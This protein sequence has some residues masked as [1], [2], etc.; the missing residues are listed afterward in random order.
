MAA[1][2]GALR[3][4]LSASIAKFQE[5]MGKAAQ[6][7]KKF[8]DGAKK[9]GESLSRVGTKMSIALTAPIVAFSIKAVEAGKESAQALGQVEAA[10]ESTGGQ[11][12]KTAVEL[13]KSAKALE[14]LSTFDDDDILK[15]VTANLLT[16]GNVQGDVFDRAQKSVVNMAARLGEDLQPAALLVGRALNDPIAAITRL[17]RA[18]I[19]LD[20]SQKKLIKSF[21]QT[22]QGVKAQ[23]IIL[24]AFE[25]KF[26]GAA[27]AARKNDPFA[28]L[29]QSIRNLLEAAGPLITG[30][31]VP[32]TDALKAI[33]DAFVALPE[34]VQGV[35][36]GLALFAATLGPMIAL[37]GNVIKLIGFLTPAVVALSAAVAGLS[38][39]I[40]ITIGALTAAVAAVVIFWKSIK[41]I[42]HGDF[43]KAWEDAKTT[44]KGMW[45]DLTSMFAKKPIIAPIKVEPIGGVKGK[46]GPLNFSLGP[47]AQKA[48]D[49]FGKAL[50]GMNDKIAAAFDTLSEPKSIQKANELNAQIDEYVRTAKEAGVNTATFAGKIAELRKQIDDLTQAGLD[51]EAQK[52][53][54]PSIRTR[55]P[56]AGSRTGRSIR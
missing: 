55:S 35:V 39:P 31:L 51:K 17:E 56:S 32:V 48:A 10:L 11:S 1:V 49:A 29:N 40:W 8:A 21:V 22:G 47:E 20:D 3:A 52:F 42:L 2:I 24:D 18:G 27:E 19:H 33:A 7:V 15:K 30:F 36:V 25:K 16:F 14:Q 53:G 41:D 4:E 5:D 43:S 45:D 50:R 54:V 23:G 34:P 26:G 38:A 28:V 6:A 37:I 46:G 44:A 13:Q 12:G 9:Q